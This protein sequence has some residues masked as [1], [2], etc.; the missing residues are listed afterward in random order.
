M[1]LSFFGSCNQSIS[2]LLYRYLY[3]DAFLF[4]QPIELRL[5]GR[6]IQS[7][8]GI[9][10]R[11]RFLVRRH[12][13]LN[14]WCLKCCPR[15][16]VTLAAAWAFIRRNHFANGLRPLLS[17]YS[18][19]SIIGFSDS[20]GNTYVTIV[21]IIFLPI[22]YSKYYHIHNFNLPKASALPPYPS[23]WLNHRHR[24]AGCDSSKSA[25]RPYSKF[26]LYNQCPF[27]L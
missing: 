24:E 19:N 14:F 10:V 23:H 4:L 7:K 22:K 20:Y 8:P 27:F 16:V 13:Y 12:R 21:N 18:T 25:L 5:L 26:P 15:A 17:K 3:P 6:H 11:S 9:P 1:F 2:F